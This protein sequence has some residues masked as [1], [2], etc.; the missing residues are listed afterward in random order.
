MNVH[1]L[2]LYRLVS[3]PAE[4]ALCAE[5]CLSGDQTACELEVQRCKCGEDVD[6]SGVELA[7]IW[8]GTELEP[9]DAGAQYCMRF[10]SVAVSG[11]LEACTCDEAIDPDA[12]T[13][14]GA[15]CAETTISAL[16]GGGMAVEDLTC[17]L[18]ASFRNQEFEQCSGATT[19][20]AERA[21]GEVALFTFEEGTGSL[22]RNQTGVVVPDLVIRDPG[23]VFWNSEG[24]TIQDATLLTTEDNNASDLVNALMATGEATLE[25]W[26]TPA[27]E[28]QYGSARIMGVRTR[29]TGSNEAMLGQGGLD[30]GEPPGPDNPGNFYN[31]RFRTTENGTSELDRLTAIGTAKAELTHLV[32]TRAPDGTET[33]YINGVTHALPPRE[34]GTDFSNWLP[35]SYL[36]MANWWNPDQ[37]RPWL[38][39]FHKVAIYSRSLS[40]NEVRE[41]YRAGPR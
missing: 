6:V 20:A 8:S 12:L 41:N 3:A 15:L 39:T 22:V 1:R 11:G 21:E 28:H 26:I 18:F 35:E 38:G 37:P 30:M 36:Y 34:S 32:A 9:E 25:A 31:I 2:E 29:A 24:L 17:N 7:N 4:G 33:V 16:G 5:H 14:G 10:V 40:A 19:N 27:F 23:N 13:D